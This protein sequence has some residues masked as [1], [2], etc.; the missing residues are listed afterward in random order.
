MSEPVLLD[1][2][3]AIWVSNDDSL[4]A[5]A[6]KAVMSAA[7]ESKVHISPISAWE[8]AT[9]VAKRRIAL[10]MS[11]EAWFYRLISLEGAVLSEMPPGVLIASVSLP[12]SPP[13]D[14]A[15]RI[16]AATAR[17]Y[18]LTLVTRDRRLLKYA[19]EG[20]LRAVRC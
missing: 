11:V 4:H 8:V 13:N 9:L 3:A 20:H 10:A 18:G 1:T 19:D 7:A 5:N 14:P 16:L 2:H 6:E 15:D 12:G 17:E